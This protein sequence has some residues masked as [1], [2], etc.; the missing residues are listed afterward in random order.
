MN[1]YTAEQVCREASG[2]ESHGYVAAPAMLR[3]YAA[4][5]RE[6]ESAKAGVTK[7]IAQELYPDVCEMIDANAPMLASAHVNQEPYC[8]TVEQRNGLSQGAMCRTKAECEASPLFDPDSDHVIPLYRDLM[9]TS[10]RVPDGWRKDV[11]LA[12][13]MLTW[14]F[15][16]GLTESQERNVRTHQAKLFAMLAAATKPEMEE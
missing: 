15:T 6:R 10:A 7:D 13:Q 2:I 12:A 9:L 14:G 5:L 11:V 1:K 8:Y 16:D 3:D 4:L